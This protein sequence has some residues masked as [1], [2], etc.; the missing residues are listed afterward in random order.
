MIIVKQYL[1]RGAVQGVGFRN[2]AAKVAK[3]NELT[4]S[5]RNLKD[6]SLKITIEGNERAVELFEKLI[7]RGPPLAR[8]DGIQVEAMSEA[9]KFRGFRILI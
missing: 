1:V 4:G 2:F 7:R 8:V 6:G 3:Q 5:V 9:S